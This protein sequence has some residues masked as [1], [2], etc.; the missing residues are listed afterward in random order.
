VREKR[1]L[2]GDLLASQLEVDDPIFYS[3]VETR[4]EDGETV[5]C[6]S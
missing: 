6:R 4:R 3:R 2:I 1:T 5:V